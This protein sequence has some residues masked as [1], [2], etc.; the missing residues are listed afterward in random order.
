MVIYLGSLVQ[1]CCGEGGTLQ[2]NITGVCGECS[3]CRNH[4]GFAPAHGTCVFLVYTAQ[5]PGCSE[6][7]LSEAG[8]GLH[9]RPRSK[10]LKFRF[11]RT[12]QRHRLVG[13]VFCALPRSRSSGDQVLGRRTTL[14]VCISSP[15]QSQL[16]SFL[17][18]PQ[19]RHLSCAMSLLWG[20]DLRLRPSLQM[21]TVQDPRKMWLA[22]GSLLTVWWRM[23]SL[24]PRFSLAFC[25]WLSPTCLSTTSG[26]GMGQ[27]TAS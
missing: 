21:A 20:S 26:R 16:L 22:T 5:A 15:P 8:P 7:E 27:A 3:Q 24:G 23:P 10:L 2:T 11:L 25:L 4:T 14:G 19:E 18:A 12:P 9:A 6:G 13:P 17:G 1:L